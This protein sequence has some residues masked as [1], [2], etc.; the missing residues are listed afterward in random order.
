MMVNPPESRV[1]RGSYLFGFLAIL[2][3]GIR[4][5]LL[6][7]DQPSFSA[8][9]LILSAFTLLYAS[10]PLLQN[11]QRT[12]PDSWFHYAYFLLQTG[13]V[14]SLASLRPVLD[15]T[16]LLYITLSLQIFHVFSRRAAIVWVIAFTLLQTTAMVLGSGWAQGVVLSLF[17]LSFIQAK[18]EQAESQILLADL[19]DAHQRLIDY[20]GQADEMAG[21]RERNRLVS[22]FHESVSQLIF[23]IVLTVRSAQILLEKEPDRVEPQLVQLQEMTQTALAEMRSLIAQ[24]RPK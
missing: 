21:L 23:S 19:Q 15:V 6:F 13:L 22:K 24:L 4:G 1:Y 8:A 9:I 11:R 18:T 20:M 14:F 5:A 10:Q 7:R 16:N 3:V 12:F 17:Y 2:L